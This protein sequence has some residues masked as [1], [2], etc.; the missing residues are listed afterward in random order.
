[1]AKGNTALANSLNQLL[2]RVRANGVLQAIYDRYFGLA[3]TP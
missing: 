1:M 2:E 3:T